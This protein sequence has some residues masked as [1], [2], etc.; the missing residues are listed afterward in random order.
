ML[1][2]VVQVNHAILTKVIEWCEHHRHDPSDGSVA[3]VEWDERFMERK[4]EE[5]Y[6]IILVMISELI[7][8]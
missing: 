8:E 5:I 3:G 6:D 1:T 4:L 7:I 2:F